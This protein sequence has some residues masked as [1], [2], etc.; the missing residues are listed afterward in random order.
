M[1]STDVYTD[2]SYRA[3]GPGFG[4]WAFV[5]VKN[6]RPI[7]DRVDTVLGTTINKM[8]FQAILEALRYFK[9]PSRLVIY[10]DSQ[11]AVFSIT[12]WAKMWAENNWVTKLGEPVKNKALLQEILEEIKRHKKVTVV[13]IRGHAGN[14]FNERADLIAQTA[15][16]TLYLQWKAQQGL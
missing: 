15:T 7:F 3:F 14:I 2:G 10:S 8:E 11:Y 4:S 12:K 5:V 6:G 9:K 1:S 13:W 16:R